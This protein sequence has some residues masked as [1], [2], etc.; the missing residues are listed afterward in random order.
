MKNEMK[1]EALLFLAR[2]VMLTFCFALHDDS[3]GGGL[4]YSAHVL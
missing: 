1:E 3:L 4:L 2:T